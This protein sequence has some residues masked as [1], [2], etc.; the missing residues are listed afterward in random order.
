MKGGSLEYFDRTDDGDKIYSFKSRNLNGETFHFRYN[1][2][3]FKHLD[4]WIPMGSTQNQRGE[5]IP[6]EF[7]NLYMNFRP[8]NAEGTILDVPPPFIA[9][10]NQGVR[11][12]IHEFMKHHETIEEVFDPGQGEAIR[13]HIKIAYNREGK[14][15]YIRSIFPVKQNPHGYVPVYK[16]R[17]AHTGT[18]HVAGYS[19]VPHAYHPDRV[20]YE[21]IFV[22][23]TDKAGP[24]MNPRVPKMLSV[25]HSFRQLLT[26]GHQ[27]RTKRTKRHVKQH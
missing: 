17:D 25:Q 26:R 1:A 21:T 22:D 8:L 23:P 10:A 24:R 3:A 19:W 18:R 16:L 5:W 9:L 20:R 7:W 4:A 11:Q 15:I 27:K 12:M 13:N 14:R 6:S 2:H